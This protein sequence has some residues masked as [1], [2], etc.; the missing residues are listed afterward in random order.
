MVLIV[1]ITVCAFGFLFSLIANSYL[2]FFIVSL[3][4]FLSTSILRPV[5]NSLIS[6]L[7]GNEQGFAMGMNN[8]Y[9]S[10]GNIIGPT[11]AGVLYDV[12]IIY[13]FILGFV[14][15]L[16][17][18]VITFMWRKKAAKEKMV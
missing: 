9:M 10:I 7:A 5:L 1:F 18:L 11:A 16:I 15:L 13:P 6:K 4:I 2:L 3:I 8:A 17:T 12:D 14:L